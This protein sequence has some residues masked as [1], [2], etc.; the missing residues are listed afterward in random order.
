MLVKSRLD[1]VYCKSS[2]GSVIMGVEFMSGLYKHLFFDGTWDL[3]GYSNSGLSICF[4]GKHAL[5]LS[6]QGTIIDNF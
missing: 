4:I 5:P 6:S 3:V 2:V 1:P